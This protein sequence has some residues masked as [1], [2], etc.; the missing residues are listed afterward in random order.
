MSTGAACARFVVNRP[1]I[2]ANVSTATTARS[3]ASG[4]ALIPQWTAAERKPVGAVM[5]PSTGTMEVCRVG[6]IASAMQRRQ[7]D[8]LVPCA[9]ERAN[10][11]VLSAA[12]ELAARVTVDDDLLGQPRGRHDREPEMDEVR[13]RMREGAELVE[14]GNR[15]AAYELVDDPSPDAGTSC[16]AGDDHR[17]HFGHGVAEGRQFCASEHFAIL[18]GDNEAVRVH[19][20]FA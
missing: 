11:R 16:L 2:D 7:G 17:P 20:N 6:A 1:A 9:L 8:A 12:P 3:S 4:F 13:G 15:R 5:P 10:H 18:R 14:P 19:Q